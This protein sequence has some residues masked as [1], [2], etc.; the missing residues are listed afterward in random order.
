[1]GS[2][3]GR[4]SPTPSEQENHDDKNQESNTQDEEQRPQAN[5]DAQTGQTRTDQASVE[6]EAE[7]IAQPAQAGLGP[8]IMM[9][10]P[11]AGPDL[12]EELGGVIIGETENGEMLIMSIDS[13]EATQAL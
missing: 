12:E 9:E 11:D 6:N 8:D 7:E 10:D 5:V 3:E 13:N 2:H 1:M 4:E